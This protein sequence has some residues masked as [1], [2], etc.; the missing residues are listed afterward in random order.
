MLMY[1]IIG[2]VVLWIIGL[3]LFMVGKYK[4]ANNPYKD[5]PKTTTEFFKQI[6][7]I[8][9]KL[10]ELLAEWAIKQAELSNMQMQAIRENSGVGGVGP[11]GLLVAGTEV[12]T[13]INP[14]EMFS[15]I[16]A[17]NKTLSYHLQRPKFGLFGLNVYPYYD[18]W[19]KKM[20]YFESNLKNRATAEEVEAFDNLKIVVLAYLKELKDMQDK[21]TANAVISLLKASATSTVSTAI[22][23]TKV[24]I[25]A[26][27]LG[28][29]VA[30]SAC[31]QNSYVRVDQ[32]G[33]ETPII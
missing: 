20:K 13:L 16:F 12:A 7:F 17:K 29:V 22:A 3:S 28:G 24:V 2:G 30:G 5:N 19:V 27:A 9:S 15:G 25:V 23:L 14:L 11:M 18:L 21:A 31:K 4:K 10:S 8:T 33:N 32:H 1:I 6:Y 26:G